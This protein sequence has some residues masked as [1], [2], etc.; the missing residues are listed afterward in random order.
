[1]APEHALKPAVVNLGSR[2]AAAK[3]VHILGRSVLSTDRSVYPEQG[4]SNGL[5]LR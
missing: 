3:P 4:R 1:M 2:C 5:S